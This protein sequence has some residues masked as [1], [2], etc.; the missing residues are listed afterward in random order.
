MLALICLGWKLSTRLEYWCRLLCTPPPLFLPLFTS[1]SPPPPPPCFLST[2]TLH[3]VCSTDFL[4]PVSLPHFYPP[5]LDSPDAAALRRP[6]FFLPA[7]ISFYPS[8]HLTSLSFPCC[9]VYHLPATLSSSTPP[10]SC[11]FQPAFLPIP[12]LISPSASP[13]ILP[14]SSALA[15]CS[16]SFSI[17]PLS[18]SFGLPPAY[19][20]SLSPSLSLSGLCR[21][22]PGLCGSRG[23]WDVKSEVCICVVSVT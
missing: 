19:S 12:L 15:F 11:L 13:C 22:I 3:S 23:W 5:H 8:L 9:S 17:C 6:K 1:S 21:L 10:P 16:L 18:C 7:L 14:V 20:V 4:P 2:H